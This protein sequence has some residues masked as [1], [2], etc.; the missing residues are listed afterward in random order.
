MDSSDRPILTRNPS[1][2]TRPILLVEDEQEMAVEIAGELESKGHLVRLATVAEAV[3][4]ARVG[5]AALIILD[6]LVFGVD[7]LPSLKLLR[8][9]GIKTPVLLISILSSVDEKVR[10]LKA[11]GDGYLAKPFAM[12]ELTARV[13]ALL[14]RLDGVRST[15]L[16]V[17]DFEM[18]LIERTV[19]CDGTKIELLP[20]EFDL[21]EYFLRRPGQ[22][23]TRAMLL[24]DLWEHH[25]SSDTNVVDAH[26]SNLRRKIDAKN[27]PSRILNIRG[28]GYML[29]ATS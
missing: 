6:R 7:C 10:G 27:L 2:D 4:T 5:G 18:D 28:A 25:F 13:E 17:G 19:Y 21:L 23:I 8:H 14:R 24:D 11:G 3:D 1:A 16:K 9:E 12:T 26:L 15:N 22:V 20:R 29:R